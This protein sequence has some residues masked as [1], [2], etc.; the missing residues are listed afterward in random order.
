MSASPVSGTG[1]SSSTTG[2][3][4]TGGKKT[5]D[6]NDF[7]QLLITQL[8]NQDPTQP[9]SNQDLLQQVTQIG[10][11]QSQNSLQDTMKQLVLQNQIASAANL[12]GKG[13]AGTDA[14]LNSVSGLVTSVQVD[15]ANSTVN[16]ELDNGQTLPL[17]NVTT[18]AT[19]PTTGT[20]TTTTTT[21]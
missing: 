6:T 8:Q 13:V 1:S 4:T 3:S 10:T 7:M 12:I 2:S 9:M 11:L 14:N 19:L 21:H 18:V 20:A 16:L 5:L 15:N 17:S